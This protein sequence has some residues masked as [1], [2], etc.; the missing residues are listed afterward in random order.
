M[1]RGSGSKRSSA[2]EGASGSNK[3][4]NSRNTDTQPN[5][6]QA[7]PSG[8]QQTDAAEAAAPRNSSAELLAA[9][10]AAEASMASAPVQPRASDGRGAGRPAAPA[11]RTAAHIAA[12]R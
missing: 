7:G 6:D 5:D 9:I 11:R 1:P 10:N 3:R 12:R 2:S 8:V 4:R